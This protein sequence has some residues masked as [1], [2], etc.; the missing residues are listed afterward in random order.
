[1]M[2]HQTVYCG[3]QLENPLILASSPVSAGKDMIERAYKSGWAGAVTKSIFLEKKKREPLSPRILPIYLN[4]Q[5]GVAGMGNIDFGMNKT[6]DELFSEYRILKEK[7]QEKMLIISIKAAYQ[8]ED[9]Q[10]L[11]VRAQESKADA[12]ELCL[13]CFDNEIGSMICQNKDAL[14]KVIGWVKDV[15]SC[16]V[17]AKLSSHVTNMAEMAEAAVQ[18]GAAAVSGINSI[19][20]MGAMNYETM[21]FAP[22]INGLC[23]PVGISGNIIK[24][25]AQYCVYE[26]IKGV[27]GYDGEVSA[28]G[29]VECG[30]DVIE[31]L[32][33]GANTI[34]MATSVMYHGYD[35]VRKILSEMDKFMEMRGILSVDELR[36][37]AYPKIKD[38]TS[39]LVQKQ[40][41]AAK[42]HQEDCVGCGRCEISCASG[43]AAAIIHMDEHMDGRKHFFVDEQKCIG[44]G[45]C[46]IVCKKKAIVLD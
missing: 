43:A 28:I 20:A 40:R 42:I 46:T 31:Y 17:I 36:G 8:K 16:P 39:Q 29:G 7:W 6:A 32:A 26:M 33:L 14:K 35:L 21:S 1:M 37:M 45:L 15:V 12:I 13:S 38:N 27:N 23:T 25:I 24:P 44:C 30:K 34:Q 22:E 41:K 4:G 5:H 18:A 19:K 2:N 10:Q 11:A 9:W 3:F